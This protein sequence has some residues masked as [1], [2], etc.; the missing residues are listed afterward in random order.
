MQTTISNPLLTVREV[1]KM[2]KSSKI[3]FA[4][5]FVINGSQFEIK[6]YHSKVSRK[7]RVMLGDR[8]IHESRDGM[9]GGKFRFCFEDSGVSFCLSQDGQISYDLTINGYSFIELWGNNMNYMVEENHQAATVKQNFS[10][11]EVKDDGCFNADEEYKELENYYIPKTV[12]KS[13]ISDIGVELE[14]LEEELDVNNP[15]FNIFEKQ[16]TKVVEKD[17]QDVQGMP[18]YRQEEAKMDIFSQYDLLKAKPSNVNLLD[19][20]P[21]AP[22]RPLNDILGEIN[23]GNEKETRLAPYGQEVNDVS[24]ES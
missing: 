10:E 9:F 2:I 4:W 21:K 24:I 15:Y 17:V 20:E 12:D 11:E 8:L 16:S 18:N 19:F 14:R 22:K 6:L 1:G 5:G 7:R 3:V 13:P 23:F